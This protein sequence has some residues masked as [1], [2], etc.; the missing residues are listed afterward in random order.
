MQ[1]WQSVLS[2]HHKTKPI[3][4]CLCSGRGDKHL[5]IKSYTRSDRYGLS[6][7]PF[8]GAQH[9]PSCKY[10]AP[11]PDKSGLYGYTDGV[12]KELD[13]GNIGIK[14]AIGLTEKEPANLPV[15]NVDVLE[16]SKPGKNQTAISLLGLLHWLWED[17]SVNYWHK[18][19]TG[20]RSWNKVSRMLS[21]SGEK[22][23][24][25][26]K[27]VSDHMVV[28]NASNKQQ[29]ENSMKNNR[30]LIIVAPISSR[31]DYKIDCE[32]YGGLPYLNIKSD[33]WNARIKKYPQE[34]KWLEKSIEGRLGHVVLIALT[35]PAKEV[36]S[37]SDKGDKRFKVNVIDFALMRVTGQWIPV[38]SSYEYKLA[39]MLVKNNRCF[40]KPLRYD[41]D[42]SVF[43]P[44]FWLKDIGSKDYPLE[45]FG[46]NTTTY[47]AKK[48]KKT[49]WY[50]NNYGNKGWW[51]WD[52]TKNEAIPQLPLNQ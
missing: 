52:A 44:D 3:I 23:R 27:K 49:T 41:A 8:S 39:D 21:D 29:L 22:L 28:A 5:T 20:K 16:K 43:F 45:V 26:R 36:K 51:S 2:T 18:N 37:N 50:N 32:Q 48:E 15:V 10:Y 19:F 38:A 11:D 40:T 4:Q 12:L 47:L 14:L 25:G 24:A 17:A 33:V 6:K 31:Q 1:K 9:E 13:Q 34:A 30:R 42:E 46:M 35:A 7:F